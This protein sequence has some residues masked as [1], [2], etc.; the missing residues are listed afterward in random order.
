MNDEDSTAKADYNLAGVCVVTGTPE[1]P[2]DVERAKLGYESENLEAG[3]TYEF[4]IEL[5]ADSEFRNV[6]AEFWQ[7]GPEISTRIGK[8]D[9]WWFTIP[10][11]RK[12]FSYE[13]TPVESGPVAIILWIGGDTGTI[14]IENTTVVEKK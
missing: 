13:I 2:D 9:A 1:K 3:K 14:H 8:Q 5:W 7:P 11:T 6:I 12:S 4:T 10:T